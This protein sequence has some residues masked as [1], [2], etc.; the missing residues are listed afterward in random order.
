MRGN[1]IFGAL[2]GIGL[3]IQDATMAFNYYLLGLG[4]V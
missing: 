2:N 4:A 3:L 1:I